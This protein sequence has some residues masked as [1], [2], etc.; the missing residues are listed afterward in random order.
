MIDLDAPQLDIQ[1]TGALAE[2][3]AA[4]LAG[5]SAPLLVQVGEGWEPDKAIAAVTTA[6][7]ADVPLLHVRADGPLGVV[8]P[9]L[10]PGAR[11]CA[12]CA[13]AWRRRVLDK[14]YPQDVGAGLP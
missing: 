13:E 9:L 7:Q 14:K 11:G 12:W 1:G 10:A 8:G 4:A 2:A 5:R 6:A 3:V